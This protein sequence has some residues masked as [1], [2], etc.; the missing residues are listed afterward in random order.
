MSVHAVILN[1]PNAYAWNCVRERWPRHYFL[2]DTVAFVAPDELI[3]LNRDIAEA[4]GMNDANRVLGV[5]L[6]VGSST[7]GYNSPA[8]WEWLGKTT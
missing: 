3:S 6:D 7:Y 1:A 5:V 2:S 4:L 8:L